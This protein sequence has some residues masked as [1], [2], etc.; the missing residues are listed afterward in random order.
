MEKVMHSGFDCPA[1]GV[2]I[3]KEFKMKKDENGL[4]YFV[5]PKGA[6]IPDE[7]KYCCKEEE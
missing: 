1:Y 5:A 6:K 2:I 3:P 4:V 7:L